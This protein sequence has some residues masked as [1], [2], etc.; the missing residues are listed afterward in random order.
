MAAGLYPNQD[1]Q[2]SESSIQC[3]ERDKPVYTVDLYNADA[4][5]A[6]DMFHICTDLS[7]NGNNQVYVS[8]PILLARRCRGF[9]CARKSA[10]SASSVQGRTC[11]SLR[12]A[13]PA[14]SSIAVPGSYAA[15]RR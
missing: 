6:R 15:V 14:F 9:Q 10:S 4:T 13:T 11:R 2:P 12:Y 7:T 1:T 5:Q 8:L 3:R